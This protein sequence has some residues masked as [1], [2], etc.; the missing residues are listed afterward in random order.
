[1][2]DAYPH[3]TE[4][5]IPLV[6]A[7]ALVALILPPLWSAR[8]RPASIPPS[9]RRGATPPPRCTF[10]QPKPPWVRREVLR[11]KALMPEHGCRKVA[12]VFNHLYGKKRKTTVG[13]TY[14]AV[15]L[16]RHAHEVLTLRRQLKHRPP[17]PLP[18]N[19]LWAL[20]LTYLPDA[21]CT[22]PV[23]G[24]VD[25]GSR[26]CLLLR[27]LRTKA[28]V[29][30]LRA[31]LDAVECFGPPRSVRTDNEAVF[32]S[33]LFRLGLAVLGIRHQRIAPFAP[34]QNGRI[35]RFFGTLKERLRPWWEIR[36]GGEAQND[37]DVFRT[38]Y[39]HLRPH[40]HLDGLTPAQKWSGVSPSPNSTAEYFS[41]WEG[42]LTGFYFPP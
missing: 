17:R 9:A 2:L 12:V 21:P 19:T 16:R 36:P 24:L 26:A 38:W 39:N 42:L 11:L 33:L 10:A 37:L 22:R 30:L 28:S 31:I 27:R 6:L 20:D 14:V 18:V 4:L 5:L 8:K 13:K 40:N 29:Q 34:W 3:L 35:E 25:A 1:M 41:A 23:L 7:L 32:T 15:L